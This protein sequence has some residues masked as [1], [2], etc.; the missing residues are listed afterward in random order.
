MECQPNPQQLD[1]CMSEAC[2]SCY[3]QGGVICTGA[4]GNCWTPILIDVTGNGF[5]LTNAAG[6]V[7]FNDGNGTVLRT[8]WTT[9]KSDDAWLVLDRNHNGTIDDGSELFGNAAPQPPTLPSELKNGFRALAEYDKSQNGGNG[10]NVIDQRDAIFVSLKLWQDNNHN[11]VSEPNELHFLRDLNLT[12][13]RLDYTLSK[14][15]DGHGN[16]FRYR[17]KVT[18]SDGAKLGR[19]AHDVFLDARRP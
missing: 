8:G 7:N 12:S 6:G 1:E 19:W 14:R 13:I 4:G 2:A 17:A 18:A 5:A 15:R 9:S 3:Q 11:G 10:D 16:T